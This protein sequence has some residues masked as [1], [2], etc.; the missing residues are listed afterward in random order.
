[1]A[2]RKLSPHDKAKLAR[3]DRVRAEF[4]QETME[5]LRTDGRL[6]DK[7]R[8]LLD[9]LPPWDPFVDV[10]EH[11]SSPLLR[12]MGIG[13]KDLILKV[14]EALGTGNKDTRAFQNSRYFVH[15]TPHPAPAGRLDAVDPQPGERRP[16][17][18]A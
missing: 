6:R 13:G 3:D 15:R 2:K 16:P 4:A 8:R 18:L 7:F 17:R 9:A 5:K 1:M 11:L 14:Q 12:K 10:T